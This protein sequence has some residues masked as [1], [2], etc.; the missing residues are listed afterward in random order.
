MTYTG[1]AFPKPK[2]KKG[3]SRRAKNNP[4]PTI[5]DRCYFTGKPYA[6]LHE[7]FFGP[8]RQN[9]IKWGMQIR[10]SPELHRVGPGAVHNNKEFDLMLKRMFQKKFEKEHGHEKFMEV[11]GRNYLD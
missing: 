1:L 10:L 8:D 11:F 7:V 4:V 2:V 6:E 3:N 9:S 5:Y